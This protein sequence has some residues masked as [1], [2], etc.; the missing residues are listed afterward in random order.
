MLFYG[1]IAEAF[2]ESYLELKESC[3]VDKR[4]RL[5]M[6]GE[7]KE[8]QGNGVTAI[9]AADYLRDRVDDQIAWYDRKS[10]ANK[11]GFVVCQIIMLAAAAAVPVVAIFSGDLWSRVVV[12]V[13]GSATV[14]TAGIASLY[15]FRGH[16]VEYRTTAESLR[17]RA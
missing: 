2:F 11:R 15:Q 17:S 4:W 7:E 1:D 10:Q 3:E 14:V 12:A 6:H 16:W 8:H 5:H 13:L 9:D